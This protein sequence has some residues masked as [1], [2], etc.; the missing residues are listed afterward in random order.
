[1]GLK[2][3]PIAAILCGLLSL[4]AISVLSALSAVAASSEQSSRDARAE[5]AISKLNDGHA[6]ESA[7]IIR[8][9]LLNL[10]LELLMDPGYSANPAELY[11]KSP[12]I[13]KDYFNT[14]I[15]RRNESANTKDIIKSLINNTVP[16]DYSAQ[17]KTYC[18]RVQSAIQQIDEFKSTADTEELKYG[19]PLTTLRED[20]TQQNPDTTVS[21]AILE[22]LGSTLNDL[23]T[24]AQQMPVGDA[25]A[26]IGLYK[27]A[28][29][30]NSAQRYPLAETFAQQSI[31]HTKAL[32]DEIAS[33]PQTQVVLAYALLKQ[34]KNEEFD[35]LK[36][37]L[38]KQIGEQDRLLITMARFCEL[39][40]DD[41]A[42]L[43][44]YEMA[45]DHRAKQRNVQK[46]EWQ[47]SYNALLERIKSN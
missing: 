44:I 1:M 28:L 29:V 35:A 6:D 15:A 21:A 30:A 34:G 26:A 2:H 12:Q 24:Q 42:A 47:D 40:H 32:T 22:K 11:A 19:D 20:D 17:L 25:R 8:Q 31:A 46:P 41:N 9:L 27:L 3:R 4:S 37:K 14:I 43:Q 10:Q 5:L 39:K 45:L 18:K 13:L 16:K 36:E 7:G 33:L 38:L 23:A